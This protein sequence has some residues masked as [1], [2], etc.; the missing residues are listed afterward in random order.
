MLFYLAGYIHSCQNNTQE[1]KANFSSG[2]KLVHK[3]VGNHELMC[4][5]LNTLSMI[6]LDR[7]DVH[8]AQQML[9]SCYVM[10]KHSGDIVAILGSLSAMEKLCM[11]EHMQEKVS[12]IQACSKLQQGVFQQNVHEAIDSGVHGVIENWDLGR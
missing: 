9:D 11:G 8:G 10:A 1:A 5:M 2:L 12:G 3:Q 6:H 4:H 7:G